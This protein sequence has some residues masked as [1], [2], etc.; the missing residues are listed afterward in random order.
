MN[1][2]GDRIACQAMPVG[3]CTQTGG[4]QQSPLRRG[5]PPVSDKGKAETNMFSAGSRAQ[6]TLA[7][8]AGSDAD[9]T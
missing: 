3:D 8:E 5:Y 6:T 9:A 7:P 2:S 1:I 4:F